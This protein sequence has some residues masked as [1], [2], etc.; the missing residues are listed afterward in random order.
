MCFTKNF[1]K[2]FSLF[3]WDEIQLLFF[4]SCKLKLLHLVWACLAVAS[5][6]FYTTYT[7]L[8]CNL[9]SPFLLQPHASNSWLLCVD[10]I[11]ILMHWIWHLALTL[12]HNLLCEFQSGTQFFPLQ[13]KREHLHTTTC[14]LDFLQVYNTKLC[15]KC[16]TY[17][18]SD[19]KCA[20]SSVLMFFFSNT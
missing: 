17:E 9:S 19:I 6:S 11:V 7:I 3:N 10:L 4:F 5:D 15:C 12:F 16:N 18:Y 2:D 14:T 8:Q 20:D 1:Q 13:N